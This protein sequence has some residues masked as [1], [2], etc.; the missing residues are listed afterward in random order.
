MRHRLASVSIA[1]ASFALTA[2][3]AEVLFPLPLHLTRQI[4]DSIGNSTTVVDQ[5]CYGNRVVAV[6][7]GITTIADYGK[8]DLTEINRDERTYSV[9]RFDDVAKALTAGGTP[10]ATPAKSEWKVRSTGRQQLRT[11]RAADVFEAELEEGEMTRRTRVAVDRSI[12]LSR[13]AL[14]ILIGA[15]Y[16]SN[17]KAEDQVVV[18]AARSRTNIAPQSANGAAAR[19]YALP[20][21]QVSTFVI[22]GQE[23]EY[24]DVVT[25]VGEELVSSDLISIPPGA[26]LVESRL[27]QRMHAVEMLDRVGRAPPTRP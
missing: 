25:R 15:A 17:R 18:D 27:V 5:Y 1:I 24:R 19:T 2:T 9:T 7:G 6:N 3:A 26:K 23:A 16:P 11:N 20:V 10:A 4:H 8:G 13:D 21:E 22:D 12:G 14:D